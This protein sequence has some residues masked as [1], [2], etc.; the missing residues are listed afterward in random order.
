VTAE[1]TADLTVW[2]GRLGNG[3]KGF[4]GVSGLR[5]S[6]GLRGVGRA[7]G[8]WGVPEKFVSQKGIT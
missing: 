2:F 7:S 6:G 8:C 4:G 3:G 5:G 1:V